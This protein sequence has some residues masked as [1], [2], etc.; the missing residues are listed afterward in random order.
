SPAA[1]SGEPA[2]DGG[3]AGSAASPVRP[4][5][6]PQLRAILDNDCA[7][8]TVRSDI[9]PPNILFVIDR[10][11]SMNCN[12]P[13]TTQSTACEAQPTRADAQ[14]PSKWEITRDALAAAMAKLPA[15]TRV[16][17]A[18]FSNDDACGVSS[19]P[20]VALHE[21][22][23]TQRSALDASLKQVQPGGG[24]PLVGATIL[25]YKYLHG[26]AL[27]NTLLGNDFVVLLTDG[28]QSEQCGDPDRCSTAAECTDLLTKMEAARAASPGSDIRTF[29][30]GA[31]GSEPARTSL[32]LI[33]RQGGTAPA[34]CSPERGDCHFD[35]TREPDFSA[36]LTEA[37]VAI[38]GQAVT[39]ELPLPAAARGDDFDPKLVNVIYSSGDASNA[40]LV[41]ED[42]RSGC[43]SA[44]GWQYN[45]DV[46]R[47]RLCGR[48]CDEVR[49]DPK[50]RLDVILGCPV[51]APQ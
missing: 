47:I 44:Q 32:S 31:P 14:R 48:V 35:M 50:A 33:A 25:A 27:S 12:P 15:S 38:A 24:T 34:G 40:R 37:L 1:G 26:L 3:G 41:P 10:S 16:A 49:A 23:K 39:C 28:A 22:D 18:Y 11:G 51:V 7:S 9:L 4:A 36:S 2:A 13:P 17:L 8:A 21:L 29:V 6:D 45:A 19:T 20:A 43:E 5:R 42:S 30:I 46:T